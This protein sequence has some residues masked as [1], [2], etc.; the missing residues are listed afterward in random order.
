MALYI[1]HSVFHSARLLCIRPETFGPYYVH[2]VGNKRF[3]VVLF[4]VCLGRRDFTTLYLSLYKVEW[5]NGE[6]G[7]IWKEMVVACS[8][9]FP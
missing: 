8:R 2:S 9:Q 1:P 5:Y 7:R 3:L 4:C 6:R